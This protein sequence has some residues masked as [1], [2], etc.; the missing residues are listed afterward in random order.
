MTFKA[1]IK[2]IQSKTGK[3]PD[4]FKRRAQELNLVT[5]GT[6]SAGVKAEKIVM[7]LKD[8][9]GLGRGHAMAIYMLLKGGRP[10]SKPSKRDQK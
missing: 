1:Y 10:S 4:D 9:Y 6:I 8:E 2:N 7:W 3:T 5:A